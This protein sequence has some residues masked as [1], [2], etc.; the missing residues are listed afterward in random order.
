MTKTL[1]AALAALTIAAAPALADGEQPHPGFITPT[2]AGG[3]V[4]AQSGES[5]GGFDLSRA[6]PLYSGGQMMDQQGSEG[7]SSF[8]AMLAPRSAV[9]TPRAG[10]AAEPAT[11]RG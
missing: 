6:M 11:S 2:Y 3:F 10:S 1:F 5:A 7:A 8:D 4:G 9:G